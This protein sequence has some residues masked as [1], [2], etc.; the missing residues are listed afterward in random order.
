MNVSGR[1][2]SPIPH[3][4]IMFDDSAGFK[5]NPKRR[6]R[7]NSSKVRPTT[8]QYLP[9]TPKLLSVYQLAS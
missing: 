5:L 1:S 2:K 6:F 3:S 7:I 9:E 4:V 8:E